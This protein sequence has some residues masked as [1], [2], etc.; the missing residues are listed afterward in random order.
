MPDL[1]HDKTPSKC[2]QTHYEQGHF[3][4]KSGRGFYDWSGKDPDT[5]RRTTTEKVARIRALMQELESD[6]GQGK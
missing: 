6:A 1:S 4:L 2:L 5:V 3:G